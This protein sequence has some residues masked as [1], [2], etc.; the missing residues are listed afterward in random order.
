MPSGL[1]SQKTASIQPAVL[2][3]PQNSTRQQP[4]ANLLK[5]RTSTAAAADAQCQAT[6]KTA[7][8]QDQQTPLNIPHRP[9]S[10]EQV[11]RPPR[12]EDK[13]Q[14][15][16]PDRPPRPTLEPAARTQHELQTEQK[17]PAVPH[18]SIKQTSRRPPPNDPS[19]QS[20]L[21][22]T[23]SAEA[24]KLVRWLT[25]VVT[26]PRAACRSTTLIAPFPNPDGASAA[27]TER[28]RRRAQIPLRPLALAVRATL[29]RVVA[30]IAL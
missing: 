10:L 24:E 23:R 25:Q 1:I 20:Q 18:R 9:T 8:A 7:T 29:S 12:L 26:C 19:R 30:P 2:T 28:H 11:I 5:Q 3:Q 4:P 21:T 14:Q 15:P 22:S 16:P 27:G 17:P 13:T 6:N